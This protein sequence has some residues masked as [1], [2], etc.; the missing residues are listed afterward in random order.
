M[1]FI[2]LTYAVGSLYIIEYCSAH[3]PIARIYLLL[4]LLLAVGLALISLPPQSGCA[5]CEGGWEG[6]GLRSMDVIPLNLC[7][8][9]Q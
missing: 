3:A 2:L 8:T 5:Q 7:V 6:G 9:E 1:N 4:T